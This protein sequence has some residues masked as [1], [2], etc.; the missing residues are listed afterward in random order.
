MDDGL[1]T[2]VSAMSSLGSSDSSAAQPSKPRRF[3][4]HGR[5]RHPRTARPFRLGPLSARGAVT[6]VLLGSGVTI[7]GPEPW[8]IQV[9]HPGFFA[10][11]LVQGSLGFGEA[12]I[13]G[14][15]DTDDLTGCLERLIRH[16]A[17][18][19][20]G[21]MMRMLMTLRHTLFNV[22]RGR[23]AWLVGRRHYDL[24]DDLFEAML[25]ARLVYSC[26]YWADAKDL[27]DA[28]V[29][30]LDLVCRKLGLA[31]G[32]RVL[33]IGCGWGEALKYAAERY[34]VQGVGV[35]IS[36]NQA[37]AAREICDGLPIEI[38]LSDYR[39]LD[40]QFDRIFSIGMFEHVGRRNHETFFDVVHRCL[41]PQ[42]LAL[43]HTIGTQAR[44]RAPDPWIERHIFPNSEIPQLDAIVAAATPHFA[45]EDVHNFGLDYARTLEAWRE[46]FDAAWPRLEARYGSAFRR[47]WHYYLAAAMASFRARR[48]HLWQFVL[49][50]HGREG[51]YRSCR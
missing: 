31:P 11:T 12:Y 4:H 42:G 34:G 2:E 24:G 8:D 26:A 15:W 33:D 45:I 39:S 27:D 1:Q 48:N 47:V 43:L 3:W 18:A 29:A 22:Q 35:T 44:R 10:K 20:V 25:G 40:E 9:H 23:G 21:V 30:K 50:P 13:D 37:V 7:D 49:A 46:R 6:H 19:R 38:R 51:V 5:R 14:W 28:Q 36:G 32:M 16:R 41:A 17:D